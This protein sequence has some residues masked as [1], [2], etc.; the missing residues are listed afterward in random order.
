MPLGIREL[1]TTVAIAGE[2]MGVVGQ[3]FEECAGQE[4]RSKD[5]RP[6]EGQVAGDQDLCAFM[7]PGEDVE[8][9]FGP[10]LGQRHEAEF[11]DYGELDLG[12]C[13][14]VA[15]EPLLVLRLNKGAAPVQRT[16]Y[17]RWQSARPRPW[18]SGS[19]SP[20]GV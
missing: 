6:F 20:R 1:I 2:D 13:L 12:Q 8:E 19:P 4:L 3:A 17:P 10:G 14:L 18:R 5:I 16:E 7:A 15:Q 9:E 11:A